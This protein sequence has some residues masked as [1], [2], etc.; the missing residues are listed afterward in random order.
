MDSKEHL[1]HKKD[2]ILYEM[3]AVKRYIEAHEYDD[4]LKEAW[5]KDQKKVEKIDHLLE[6]IERKEGSAGQGSKR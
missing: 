5:D 2:E 4:Q 6:R 3:N 1:L